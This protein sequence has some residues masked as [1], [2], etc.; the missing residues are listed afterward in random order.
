MENNWL[1]PEKPA[2]LT[3]HRLIAAILNDTFPV[4]TNLPAERELASQL[5]VTRPTLREALQRLARDGWLEI[6]QGK[7]TRVRNYY[8]E[9]NLAVLA[10]I[11]RQQEDLPPDFVP[12]LLSVRSLLAPAYTHLAIERNAPNIAAF[13]ETHPAL[14]E[15]A[16]TY[17]AFDWDLHHRLT[18]ASG[19]T[20]FTLILNG[21]HHLYHSMGERY[22]TLPSARVSSRAWYAGLLLAARSRDAVRAAELTR[23]VMLESMRIWSQVQVARGKER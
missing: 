23:Q 15:Q 9:G 5:G 21:F 1:P 17:S 8:V 18:V 10:A 19:N 20:V 14:P 6:H 3:E 22:F 16:S 2:E 12:N 11:A 13:L 7:P 4:D